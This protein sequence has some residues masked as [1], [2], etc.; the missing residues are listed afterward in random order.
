MSSQVL[1]VDDDPFIRSDLAGLLGD[2]DFTAEAARDGRE[3]QDKL[4]TDT[5]ELVLL[6][7]ELPRLS[8][9]KLLAWIH[10]SMPSL[11]VIIVSGKATISSAVEATRLGAYDI[12]EKPV[13]GERLIITVRNALEKIRLTKERD[14]LLMEKKGYS[15]SIIGDGPS[16]KR[17]LDKIDK[18]SRIDVS[19]MITGE[20][21][22]GKELVA[23]GIHENSDRRDA[24]FIAVNCSAIPESL[25]ESHF[26]GHE[27][28]AFTGAVLSYTGRFLQ[29]HKGTLFLDELGDMS[30]GHQAK[31]LRVLDD[32]FVEPV[33]STRQL[34]FDVRIVAATNKPIDGANAFD[35][36]R[37]DLFHRIS[38]LRIEL[39]PLRDRKEDII[40]LA[41]HFMNRFCLDHGL[42]SR[43][44]TDAAKSE[45][46]AHSWSG[47]VRE[48]ANVVRRLIIEA[49]GLQIG[50]LAVRQSLTPGLLRDGEADPEAGS[51]L[52]EARQVFEKDFIE[53]ALLVHDGKIQKTAD[54]LGITR[55][56][57]W[58]KMREYGIENE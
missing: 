9:L 51:S 41:E 46:L 39:P 28:G 17:I 26:F 27:K 24:P 55:A 43:T 8:G 40:L 5:F 36:I 25:F 37:E 12:L 29:A 30:P 58:K 10:D 4:K 15:G 42:A 3:A 32:G 18:A 7:L 14:T 13:S 47:N 2:Y 38:V 56:H 54:A 19:V 21:G 1:I 34:P 45:L 35:F 22:T 6:D 52:R 53:K 44:L 33:G 50:Q 11:E 16:I 31:L 49:D 23:R 20:S 48:L 57:L